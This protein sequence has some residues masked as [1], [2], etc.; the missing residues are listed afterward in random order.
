MESAEQ[1]LFNCLASTFL[2]STSAEELVVAQCNS[3]DLL[4]LAQQ[5]KFPTF[6]GKIAFSP[7]AAFSAEDFQKLV[8]LRTQ[9]Q[10][11]KVE[12]PEDEQRIEEEHRR[13]MESLHAYNEAK[14]VGQALLGKLAQLKG[15]TTK[16]LYPEF[17]LSLEE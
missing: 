4:H 3:T 5:L 15:M 14:D 13:Y 2:A 10:A 12:L 17:G 8:E 1:R 16:Q 11:I 7:Q 9:L 6:A